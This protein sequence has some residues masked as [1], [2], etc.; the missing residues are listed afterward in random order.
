MFPIRAKAGNLAID[1]EPLAAWRE[2]PD[3]YGAILTAGDEAHPV[4]AECHIIDQPGMTNQRQQSV[5]GSG[6]PDSRRP[7]LAG[8]RQTRSVW[9]EGQ[10]AGGPL[11]IGRAQV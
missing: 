6:I 3:F 4:G 9:A 11:E 7:I 2:V 5:P 1:G 8:C 10:A